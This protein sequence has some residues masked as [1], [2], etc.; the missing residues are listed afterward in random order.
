MIILL[1]LSIIFN[2]NF[3]LMCALGIQKIHFIQESE[4]LIGIE[5]EK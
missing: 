5:N 4:F 1:N 2:L 3:K